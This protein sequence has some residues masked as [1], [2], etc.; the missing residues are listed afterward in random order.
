MANQQVDEGLTLDRGGARMYH[1][2]STASVSEAFPSLTICTDST[3]PSG[4]PI[5]NSQTE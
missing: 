4:P 5:S 3:I 1:L 2:Q